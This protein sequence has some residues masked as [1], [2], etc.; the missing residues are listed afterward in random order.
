MTGPTAVQNVA[1]ETEAEEAI[2]GLF[3]TREH[4]N[5]PY[6]LFRKLREARPVHHSR[7]L[8]AWVLSRLVDVRS[9]LVSPHTELRNIETRLRP[10]WQEHASSRNMTEYLVLRDD[11]SHRA[12]RSV[13][14]A[15][16]QRGFI[17]RYRPEVR[18][19][20]GELAEEFVARGGGNF[21]TDVAYEL[22][23]RV[24]CMI[25]NV[26]LDDGMDWQRLSAEFNLCHEPDCTAE[27]ERRADDAAV[28]IRK[29]WS[30]QAEKRRKAPG[31]DLFTQLVDGKLLDFH[32]GTVVAESLF[33]GGFETT[34]LAI[35]SG[36]WN[37]LQNPRELQRVRDD[38]EC[39]RF[40]TDE[41]LRFCPPIMMTMRIATKPLKLSDGSVIAPDERAIAFIASANRDPAAFQDAERFRVQAPTGAPA[42]FGYGAHACLGMWLAR[43]E[44]DEIFD[45]MFERA[46]EISFRGP[47]PLFRER[48]SLRGPVELMLDVA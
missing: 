16:W 33:I 26:P 35:A 6:P 1:S 28:T 38:M 18:R 8:N 29:F 25:L 45:A 10:D 39:R 17:E 47:P 11:P 43:M 41:I 36:M 13:L 42:Y 20:A 9:V 31:D 3:C 27:E 4:R 15:Q 30:D 24:I 23:V 5:D 34:T 32:T 19:I 14:S 40:L 12:I 46:R 37:L 21:L 7:F 22:P 2:R 44:I 48:L